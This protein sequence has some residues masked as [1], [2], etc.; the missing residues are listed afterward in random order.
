MRVPTWVVP[1][2]VVLLASAGVGISQFFAIPTVELDL[3]SGAPLPHRSEVLSLTVRGVRCAD[4][5][6]SA[7]TNLEGL[8][9][10]F[11]Y[12]AYASRGRVDI[13]IDPGVINRESIIEAIEGPVFDADSGEF[14][15][16]VFDVLEE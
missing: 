5:A 16:A 6:R 11:S 13:T 14:R 12:V 9:G 3:A 1:F 10:V 2:L 8:D 15:F 4:T 7:A